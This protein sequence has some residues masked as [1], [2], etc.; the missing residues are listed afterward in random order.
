MD[1][2]E[3]IRIDFLPVYHYLENKLS[4]TEKQPT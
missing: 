3:K 4:P 1:L 2:E